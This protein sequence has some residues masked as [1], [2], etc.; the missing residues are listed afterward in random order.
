MNQEKVRQTRLEGGS[1]SGLG[2]GLKILANVHSRIEVLAD[3][4]S[5]LSRVISRGGAVLQQTK[6]QMQWISNLGT[7]DLQVLGI[8]GGDGPAWGGGE[9]SAIRSSSSAEPTPKDAGGVATSLLLCKAR[10]PGGP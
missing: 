5:R 8:S 10:L 2:V 3:V 1:T 6:V 4:F 9:R 7:T